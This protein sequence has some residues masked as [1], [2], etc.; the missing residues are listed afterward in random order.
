M[1]TSDNKKDGDS[2]RKRVTSPYDLNPN[3]NPGNLVT[4]VQLK[5]DNYDEWAKAICMS[6]RS[7]KKLGF[8]D[9]TI[10]R[11]DDDSDDLEDW[12]TVNSMLVSWIF[13]TIESTLR[14]TISYKDSAFDLWQDIR[15]RFRVTNGPRIQQLKVA[16]VE[17]KQGNS[18]ISDYYGR[19]KKLWEE[20]ADHDAIPMCHC[21][22]CTC[23]L[24]KAFDKRAEDEKVHQFLMGLNSDIYGTIRST[25]LGS[26][27]LPNM[28]KVYASMIREEQVHTASSSKEMK[29]EVMSFV[30]QINPGRGREMVKDPTRFCT[31]CKRTGHEA[32]N[33]FQL[34]GYPDWW[35]DRTRGVGRGT[36]RGKGTGRGHGGG[37]GGQAHAAMASGSSTNGA[38]EGGLNQNG[39]TGITEDQWQMLRTFLNAQTKPTLKM[40]GKKT[41]VT[42]I[43]DTR[44]SNH[45][46]GNLELLID[47]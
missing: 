6:M 16:V 24:T 32:D 8:L 4:H 39:L 27:P 9:G 2:S 25:I 28:N 12:Y 42:W 11:P 26:D 5:G 35:G 10:Q 15:E 41:N 46:T 14:S 20:L 22:R 31:H 40:T 30:A 7:K 3:D 19:M 44:A 13:N 1:A 37:R 18:T 21:G 34:I 45:M 23:N 29:G 38:L 43:I 47:L 36:G 17:C 33:C